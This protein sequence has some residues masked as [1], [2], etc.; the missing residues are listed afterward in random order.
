M[1]SKSSRQ[2]AGGVPNVA[3]AATVRQQT[4]MHSPPPSSPEQAQ[5]HSRAADRDLQRDHED[6]KAKRAMTHAAI[7]RAPD[8]AGQLRANSEGP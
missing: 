6:E 8:A 4:I 2:T 7:L 5:A 1:R 3:Q